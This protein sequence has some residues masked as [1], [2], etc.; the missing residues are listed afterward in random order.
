MSGISTGISGLS[1]NTTSKANRSTMSHIGAESDIAP[2]PPAPTPNPSGIAVQPS[3]RRTLTRKNTIKGGATLN[4][5]DLEKLRVDLK[6]LQIG[7]IYPD[8]CLVPKTRGTLA[9]TYDLG[10]GILELFFSRQ[11]GKAL[12]VYKNMHGN[13]QT[14]YWEGEYA[15]I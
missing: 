11:T 8:A 9:S 7:P 15:Y 3:L 6:G 10:R 12:A 1:R 2:I 14:I 5:G 4:M 13:L